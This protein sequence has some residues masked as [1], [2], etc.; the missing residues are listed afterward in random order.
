MSL[1]SRA[2]WA[3]QRQDGFLYEGLHDLQL[4]IEQTVDCVSGC[5]EHTAIL[6][7]DDSCSLDVEVLSFRLADYRDESGRVGCEEPSIRPHQFLPKHPVDRKGCRIARQVSSHIVD[8]REY[9]ARVEA[10]G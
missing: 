3:V 4:Q 10:H 7:L 2:D 8:F 1:Y 5:L 6:D 9:I